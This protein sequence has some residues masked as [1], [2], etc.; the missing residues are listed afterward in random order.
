MS[1]HSH[2]GY[3]ARKQPLQ[4]DVANARWCN[5]C[6]QLRKRAHGRPCHLSV[7]VTDDHV[8]C[9]LDGLTCAVAKQNWMGDCIHTH[10]HL[11]SMFAS[12]G[13]WWFHYYV[14]PPAE[15]SCLAE[16]ML[17]VAHYMLHSFMKRVVTWWQHGAWHWN[18]R[19]QSNA[20]TSD[21]TTEWVMTNQEYLC[22]Q[23]HYYLHMLKP[24]HIQAT[25][26]H[27]HCPGSEQLQPSNHCATP[28]GASKTSTAWWPQAVAA[29]WHD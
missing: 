14:V 12:Q 1:Q 16:Y 8:Q 19:R 29:W 26:I 28:L 22:P 18:Q 17:L 25:T 15:P 23:P 13:E 11:Q 5:L 2:R 7:T 27:I 4:R 6:M 9:Y 20:T 21:T 10:K 24:S 3:V